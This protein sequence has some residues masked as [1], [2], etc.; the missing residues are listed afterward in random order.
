MTA[1]PQRQLIDSP[2]IVPRSEH[3]ISRANISDNALKVLYRLK[4][5]GF[6]AFLVGG[7]VRDLL[8]GQAPKDFDVATNAHPEQVRELF[9]NSRV[10]GR[11]FRLVHVRFGREVIEVATFRAAPDAEIGGDAD[12]TLHESGRILRDNVFG[13]IEEDA[14]RRDFTVNALYYDI[15]DFSVWD[16]VGGLDDLNHRILRLIGDPV[17]RYR[18]DPVRMLRAARFA[19][20]HDFTIEATNERALTEMAPLIADV[21]AARLF[22]EILKLF[23]SGY[24]LKNFRTLRRYGLFDQLFPWTE[25]SL[26]SDASVEGFV[27]RALANTDGRIEAGLPVTPAFLFAALL[28]PPVRT[29]AA[30]READGVRGTQ[31]FRQAAIDIAAQQQTRIALP[32]RF[33]QPMTEI[34]EL[35]ARFTQRRGKRPMRL[36]EHPRFR[37]GYDFLLL[38][39]ETGEAE[40][41]LADW[42]TALQAEHPPAADAEPRPR[43]RRRRQRAAHSSEEE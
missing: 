19:T 16:Y 17:T 32:R 41:E 36:L 14:W 26:A 10:I 39:A 4:D 28:W 34:F 27:E 11:R 15:S 20:K 8:L 5:A 24:A 33:K 13:T 7:S 25:E 40:Q 1:N 21:P 37:A 9:R 38:R 18:E 6:T 42:W 43:R 12:R 2:N 29:Y 31:A 23:M 22:D 30:W 35:Q 3:S